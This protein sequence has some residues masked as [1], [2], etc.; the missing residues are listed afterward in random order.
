MVN[1]DGCEEQYIC[2]S[3]LYLMSD[4]SQCYSIIIDLDMSA[5]RPGEEI[6]DGLNTI[7]KRFIYQLISNVQLP[8]SKTFDSQILMY[9]FTENN[10][11]SLALK[12]Q[13]IFLTSIINMESLIS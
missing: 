7:E 4:F 2:A 8:G 10:Y 11:V 12:F 3:A 1:T 6:V 13:T 9:S 5:P